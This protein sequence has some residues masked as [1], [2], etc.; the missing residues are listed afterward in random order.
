MENGSIVHMVVAAVMRCWTGLYYIPTL[1]YT[2]GWE[3]II[4]TTL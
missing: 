4:P 2:I 3:Y 1:P